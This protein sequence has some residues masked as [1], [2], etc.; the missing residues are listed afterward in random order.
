MRS[1]HKK[2]WPRGRD[3]LHYGNQR[4][5]RSPEGGGD[6]VIINLVRPV[7]VGTTYCSKY[8]SGSPLIELLLNKQ[9][10]T[11]DFVSLRVRTLFRLVSLRR[12]VVLYGGAR[13]AWWCDIC[14]IFSL[15]DHELDFSFMNADVGMSVLV[16]GLYV[17][18]YSTAF[19]P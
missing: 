16:P 2:F 10:D 8:R 17:A 19:S 9:A 13:R 5:I 18:L 15:M 1:G 6:L 4:F 12:Y 11:D 14:L 7:K 3:L